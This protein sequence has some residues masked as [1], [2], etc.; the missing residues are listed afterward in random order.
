MG[1]LRDRWQAVW[2]RLHAH[3]VP[4]ELLDQLI[5]AYSSPERFY[6]NW[7]HIEDCLSMFDQTTSLAIRPEE[8]ELAIWFHDAVYDTR[9]SDNEQRSAEWARAVILQFVDDHN[10]ASRVSELILSTRHTR[11]A[12]DKD[13]QLIVDI[14][15]SIL[16]R[17]SGVFWRYEQNIR[18]EY[19][20]VPVALF[21]QRRAE[22]LNSFLARQFIYTH[23]EYRERFEQ[24]AR[25]N[26]R[27]AIT[28]LT[29]GK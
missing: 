27:Q 29:E 24:R 12:T 16:G 17:E 8:V 7:E 21:Q 14:D 2:Q 9:R 25:A 3:T 28:R 19:A 20:W 1:N 13:S 4:R 10:V 15:L 5:N 6:H 22:I 26:L 23:K 11:E 18:R